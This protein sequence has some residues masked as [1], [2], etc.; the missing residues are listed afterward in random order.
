MTTQASKP[1]EVSRKVSLG[2]CNGGVADGWAATSVSF[3]RAGPL[4][5]AASSWPSM[6]HRS[7]SSSSSSA[8]S[9]VAV[10]AEAVVEVAVVTVKPA[11]DSSGRVQIGQST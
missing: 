7:A 8:A 3:S 5:A 4:A 10:A 11:A 2:T 6:M 9:S 1:Y